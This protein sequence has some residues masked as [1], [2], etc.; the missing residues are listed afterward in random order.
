MDL[1]KEPK[2]R[3]HRRAAAV[4][5]LLLTLSLAAA[6]GA[7][8]YSFTGSASQMEP[9]ELKEETYTGPIPEPQLEVA[10]GEL[11]ARPSA[12]PFPA[13]YN[14]RSCRRALLLPNTREFFWPVVDASAAR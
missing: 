5:A 11:S 10:P 12:P 14:R 4:G 2:P 6:A 13:I 1:P 3:W 7:F 8:A 9:P